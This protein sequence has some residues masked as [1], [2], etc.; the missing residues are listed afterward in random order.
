MKRPLIVL[1]PEPGNARTAAAIRRGGG[2]AVAAP[3]FAL[4]PLAWTPPPAGGFDALALTSAN[5]VRHAGPELARYRDLPAY[6]VGKATAEA[7]TAAGLAVRH[8]GEGDGAALAKAALEDGV[9]HML[10]LCGRAHRP[11]ARPGLEVTA[12]P[13][14]AAEAV[15]ALPR[16]A[17]GAMRDG[18]VALIHSPRAGALLAGLVDARG[19]ARGTVAIAAISE[20][21]AAAAGGGWR[22]VAVAERPDDDAL[23]AA[24]LAMCDHPG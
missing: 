14:Y 10:H 22:E 24:A 5:A 12:C 9:R 7:A 3:L 21:A 18:A 19:I 2:T 20:P 1:R 13:V 17:E 4:R 15:T 23:L 8:I 16:D 6:A 11:L